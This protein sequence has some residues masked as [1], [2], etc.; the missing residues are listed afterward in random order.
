MVQG[1]KAMLSELELALSESGKWVAAG[2][3]TVSDDLVDLRSYPELFS[4]G[5]EVFHAARERDCIVH[6]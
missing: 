1:T 4:K 5:T 2:R 3:D 6:A